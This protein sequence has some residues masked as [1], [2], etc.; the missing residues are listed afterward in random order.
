MADRPN[1]T[2]RSALAMMAAGGAGAFLA[3]ARAFAATPRAMPAQRYLVFVDG[4]RSGTYH[5]EFLPRDGGFTATSSMSI[6]V[7]VAFIT[8][9]RYQQD[10]QEDWR[11]GKLVGFEYVT[12]D[13]GTPFLVSG[14]RKGEDMAV[15][16][17]KGAATVPGNISC[18]GFWNHNI[19]YAP[20]LVDPQTGEAVPL[21]IRRLSAESAQIAK[22]AVHGLG[23]AFDTFLKGTIWYD[24]HDQLLATS[25]TQQGH[26]VEF[27]R[28]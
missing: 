13:D 12:N 21:S 24:S 17:P 25:F 8:A 3:P 26:K 18:S 20:A 15:S 1:P 16:G 7:E 11:G 28:A 14:R 5:V 22:Q 27:R 6:R 10:G 23:Y 9:Y 2:R 19:I 4:E